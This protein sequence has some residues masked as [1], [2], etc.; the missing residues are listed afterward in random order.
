LYDLPFFRHVVDVVD[1]MVGPFRELEDDIFE[2]FGENAKIKFTCGGEIP[3]GVSAQDWAAVTSPSTTVWRRFCWEINAQQRDLSSITRLGERLQQFLETDKGQGL[4]LDRRGVL[5]GRIKILLQPRILVIDDQAILAA[6][7]HAF[8]G[9]QTR[10][11]DDEPSTANRVAELLGRLGPKSADAISALEGS[12]Q[13]FTPIHVVPRWRPSE[14]G[15]HFHIGNYS[16][17]IEA[18]EFMDES[19]GVKWNFCTFNGVSKA[20]TGTDVGDMGASFTK[21]PTGTFCG[22]DLQSEASHPGWFCLF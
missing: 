5:A 1:A 8:E 20:W 3:A 4:P 6:S 15:G 18:H 19:G 14:Y 11:K 22:M 12:L 17:R 21:G 13:A 9:M 10:C 2:I 16:S 7:K